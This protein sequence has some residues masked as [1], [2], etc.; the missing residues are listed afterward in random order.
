MR[1]AHRKEGRV[2]DEDVLGHGEDDGSNEPEVGEGAHHQQRL[3]L[4][5]TR[6]GEGQGD[7]ERR[8]GGRMEGGRKE[9]WRGEGG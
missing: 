8:E 1:C 5:H 3:V 7:R 4:T 2:E 6:R 9:E